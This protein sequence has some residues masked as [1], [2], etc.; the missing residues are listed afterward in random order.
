MRFWRPSVVC[1]IVGLGLFVSGFFL[2]AVRFP[3]DPRPE[4]RWGSGSISHEFPGW[5]CAE[6]T[7]ASTAAFFRNPKAE[8]I[9]IVVSGWINPLVLFYLLAGA[10]KRL[11][12]IRPII[13]GTI[14]ACC[15][16]MWIQLAA[17]QVALLAGHYLWIAGIALIL[18]APWAGRFS[19]GN[20]QLPAA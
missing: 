13:A 1:G 17:D 20:D 5:L 19:S 12:R 8:A 15:A 10:V 4:A 11:R 18:A 2:P 7:L 14:A 9:P 3:P 6:A 16:A